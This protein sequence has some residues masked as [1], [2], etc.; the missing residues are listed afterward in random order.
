MRWIFFSIGLQH[1]FMKQR[2]RK[3]NHVNVDLI[4][5]DITCDLSHMQRTGGFVH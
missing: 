4:A 2:E 5:T 1:R 3:K